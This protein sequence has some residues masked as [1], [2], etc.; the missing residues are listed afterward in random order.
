MYEYFAVADVNTSVLEDKD[1]IKLE[2]EEGL[3][4]SLIQIVAKFEYGYLI[5]IQTDDEC[6]K[7]MIKYAEKNEYSDQFI[8]L[9]RSLKS[10]NFAYV[11]LDTEGLTTEIQP[12]P[13]DMWEHME[14]ERI[15][16][17]GIDQPK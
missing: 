6:F 4:D 13:S 15:R 12:P 14:A 7:E 16:E 2:W 5:A 1:L 10:Y 3:I 8:A 9:M 17:H 11:R